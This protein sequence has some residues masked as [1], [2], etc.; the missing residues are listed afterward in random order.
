MPLQ[1]FT[2]TGTAGFVPRLLGQTAV[3]LACSTEKSSNTGTSS[4]R[5]TCGVA[6]NDAVTPTPPQAGRLYDG[7]D[8]YD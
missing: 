1:P 8:D 6:K 3:M 2:N 5:S 4:P 7:V